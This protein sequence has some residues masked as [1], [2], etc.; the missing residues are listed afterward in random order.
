MLDVVG[1]ARLRL[2]LAAYEEDPT[3]NRPFHIEA[4][5]EAPTHNRP[6]HVGWLGLPV[7]PQFR[8]VGT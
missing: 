5:E 7:H 4:C 1:P 6:C 2:P 8:S 3:Y